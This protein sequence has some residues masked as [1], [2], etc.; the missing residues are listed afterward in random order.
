[1][2]GGTIN[3]CG[4]G[5]PA[6]SRLLLFGTL[7]G[8]ASSALQVIGSPGT[9][10]HGAMSGNST[11]ST[12]NRESSVSQG[13]CAEGRPRSSSSETVGKMKGLIKSVVNVGYESSRT[14]KS[15]GERE[16]AIPRKMDSQVD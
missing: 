5:S 4:D 3:A 2:K 12:G 1:M 9:R 14:E 10:L 11:F 8:R 6:F 13:T 15:N 7:R 16:H